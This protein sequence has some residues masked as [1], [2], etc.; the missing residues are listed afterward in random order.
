MLQ[1]QYL[2]FASMLSVKYPVLPATDTIPTWVSGLTILEAVV[3]GKGHKIARLSNRFR[4]S[5]LQGFL[6]LEENIR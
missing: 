5:L 2:H 4:Y 1:M 6:V 3:E